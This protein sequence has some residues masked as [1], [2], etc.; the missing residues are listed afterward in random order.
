MTDGF[1]HRYFFLF[2]LVLVGVHINACLLSNDKK[3]YNALKRNSATFCQ[4]MV[5]C[6]F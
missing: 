6:F 3:L 1:L 4:R 5:D 2:F